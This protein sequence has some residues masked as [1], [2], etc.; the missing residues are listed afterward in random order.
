MYNTNNLQPAYLEYAALKVRHPSFNQPLEPDEDGLHWYTPGEIFC[1]CFEDG[2]Q[3][4]IDVS[5]LAVRTRDM[6]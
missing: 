1:R 2:K 3:C 5:T 6:S 4:P